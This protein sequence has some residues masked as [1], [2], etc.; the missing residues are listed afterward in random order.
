VAD[1]NGVDR[2][3]DRLVGWIWGAKADA[4]AHDSSK[5]AAAVTTAILVHE[6]R[7]MV[8]YSIADVRWMGV[9][10]GGGGVV[11]FIFH[12]SFFIRFFV[13]SGQLQL[14]TNGIILML[15]DTEP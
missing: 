1:N 4:M 12:G 11:A 3:R 5:I 9:K 14:R 15:M 8:D 7:T 13:S 6:R 10:W 2:D